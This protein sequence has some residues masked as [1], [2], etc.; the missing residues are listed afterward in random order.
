MI[1]DDFPNLSRMRKPQ[2][3]AALRKALRTY[4]G[5]LDQL[6]ERIQVLEGQRERV[7]V[8]R[9]QALAEISRLENEPKGEPPEAAVPHRGEPA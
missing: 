5:R 9:Q 4:K 7:L 1:R 6:A 3:L 2:Q 8:K